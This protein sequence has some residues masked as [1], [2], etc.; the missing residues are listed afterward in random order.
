MCFLLD[1]RAARFPPPQTS[2]QQISGRLERGGYEVSAVRQSI[3]KPSALRAASSFERASP[4]SG[5]RGAEKL[6]LFLSF[7]ETVEMILLFLKFL[8]SSAID[9]GNGPTLFPQPRDR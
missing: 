8:V 5:H 4:K 7:R 6:P 2:A 9:T 3:A 1:F